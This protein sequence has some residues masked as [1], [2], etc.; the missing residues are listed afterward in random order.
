MGLVV[1]GV[2]L[3]TEI[4]GGKAAGVS[5]GTGAGVGAEAGAGAEESGMECSTE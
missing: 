4:T 3:S 5:A 2:G 1:A